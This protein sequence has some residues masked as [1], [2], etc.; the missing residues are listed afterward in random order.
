MCDVPLPEQT[1]CSTDNRQ[2]KRRYPVW[3]AASNVSLT[4]PARRCG[5]RDSLRSFRLMSLPKACRGRYVPQSF[6][7][8]L[9]RY[10]LRTQPEATRILRAIRDIGPYRYLTKRWIRVEISSFD[11]SSK[12]DAICSRS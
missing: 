10:R 3:V 6:Y 2:Q 9:Q 11:M 12:V 1:H 4:R 7:E 5:L 8:L